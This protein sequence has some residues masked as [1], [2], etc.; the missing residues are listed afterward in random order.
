MTSNL[1]N[2]FRGPISFLSGEVIS[3]ATMRTKASIILFWLRLILCVDFRMRV[4]VFSIKECTIGLFWLDYLKL[5]LTF[6]DQPL[7]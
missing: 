4:V 7:I 3:R 5:S 6:S 2:L 1:L